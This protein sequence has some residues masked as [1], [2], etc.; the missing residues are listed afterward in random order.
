[1]LI[2]QKRTSNVIHYYRMNTLNL[3][4]NIYSNYG[5]RITFEVTVITL[6]MTIIKNSNTILL[7]TNFWMSFLKKN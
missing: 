3:G 2:Y 5:S 4:S 1:M 6:F 7:K